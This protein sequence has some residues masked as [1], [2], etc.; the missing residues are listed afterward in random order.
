[1]LVDQLAR[2]TANSSP[3][4]TAFVEREL[5]GVTATLSGLATRKTARQDSEH[6]N[7]MNMLVGAATKSIIATSVVGPPEANLPGS[8]FWQSP[9][10]TAYLKRQEEA[11]ARGVEVRRLFMA[12]SPE[13]VT[14]PEFTRAIEKNV[15]YGVVVR[16]LDRLPLDS[17]IE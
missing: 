11:S 7:W 12:Y 13:M 3:L 4:V 2:A 14:R 8:G 15:S 1:D 9:A 10:S 17:E 16:W 6:Y 5:E